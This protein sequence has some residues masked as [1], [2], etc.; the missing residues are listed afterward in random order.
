LRESSNKTKAKYCTSTSNYIQAAETDSVCLICYSPEK[1]SQPPTGFPKKIPSKFMVKVVTKSE[2][3]QPVVHCEKTK[4]RVECLVADH[5]ESI[6]LLLW[7]DAIEK[8]HSS[9]NCIHDINLSSPSLKD[10]LITA[11][12]VGV[13]IKKCSCLVCNSTLD[14]QETTEETRTCPNCNIT[15]ASLS[16]PKGLSNTSSNCRQHFKLHLIQ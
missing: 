6:K 2:N 4:Y 13:D 8:V 15:L 12:C 16:K 10:N 9:K 14:T 1:K 3:K 5:T 7:E 11:K